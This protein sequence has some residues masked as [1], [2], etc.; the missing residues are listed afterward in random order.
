MINDI[1]VEQ[2]NITD[3]SLYVCISLL[4]VWEV[5]I[6]NK[7]DL[8]TNISF[9]QIFYTRVEKNDSRHIYV[10]DSP[11]YGVDIAVQLYIIIII[12]HI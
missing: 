7:F 2:N 12:I 1:I 9:N 5:S 3:A 6:K 11:G 8:N 10:I 4:Y